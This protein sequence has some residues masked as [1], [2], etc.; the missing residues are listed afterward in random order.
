[1]VKTG[2]RRTHPAAILEAL[3]FDFF[4]LLD[5]VTIA[6]SRRHIQT[7]YDTQDIGPF[8]ERLKP[9]SVHSPLTHRPDVIG[10]NEIFN[11]LSLLKL[12]VYAPI[13][14]ILP[15]RLSKYEDLYDTDVSGRGT[16]KQE[17]R[18]KSLQTLM[19]VN[20]LKRLESSVQA[21]RLTLERLQNLHLATLAKIENFR[22]TGH[23]ADF[24][25]VSPALRIRSRMTT[26]HLMTSSTKRRAKKSAEKFVSVCLIWICRPGTMTCAPT[27]QSSRRC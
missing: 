20:L 11:R 7:F 14:Y 6:R 10:F 2:P 19:T 17:D 15:S 26:K 8:P 12:G 16:L 5:S 3:D 23:D 1:M 27:S 13:G 25:D 18:E 21:F 24:T 4:E 22:N 9:I